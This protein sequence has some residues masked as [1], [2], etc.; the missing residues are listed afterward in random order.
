ML[1]HWTPPTNE[2]DARVELAAAYRMVHDQGWTDLGATHLSAAVPGEDAYLMLRSGLLFDEVTASNL[3]KIGDDGEIR[4]PGCGTGAEPVEVNPA[5]V[6]I[7]SALHAARPGIGSVMHTHTVAGVAVANH[8]DGV[9]PLSQ[10]AMRFWRCH[11]TH[12]YEGIAL[13]G[14]EG[15]RLAADLGDGELLLLRNHGLLTV[16]PD[17]PSAFSALYY[18]EF[19]CRIQL[20]SFADPSTPPV[21]PDRETCDR[22]RA[23]YEASDGYCYRDWMAVLRR[24]EARHPDFAA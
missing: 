10:H 20:A 4:E 12:D 21:V 23:Q 3:V 7:H 2:R 22:T 18:A 6:T 19:S 16:G 15:P 11:G 17:V 8:P 5:G 14:A 1:G 24:L 13:D 9:L